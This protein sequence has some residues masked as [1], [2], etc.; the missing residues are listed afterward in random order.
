M[1]RLM[2]LV[3]IWI[4][5]IAEYQAPNYQSFDFSGTNLILKTEKRSTVTICKQD[6]PVF[7]EWS[8]YRHNLGLKIEWF[9][10]FYYS[11]LNSGPNGY[12]H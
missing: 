9:A 2:I 12:S 10:I 11:G 7:I 4:P 8:F 5:T 6:R 1:E 3:K